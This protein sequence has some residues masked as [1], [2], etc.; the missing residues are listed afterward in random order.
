MTV[1][2]APG[3]AN[4]FPEYLRD[5]RG[6]NQACSVGLVCA[7]NLQPN[8]VFH[9]LGHAARA[10]STNAPVE[11][12]S[13][14][15]R[16]QIKSKS[17]DRV[18]T[19]QG[20]IRVLRVWRRALT[21]ISVEFITEQGCQTGVI[22]N[23]SH[24]GAGLTGCFDGCRG[25]VVTLHFN[26]G[27]LIPA[28]VR[29][30]RGYY[31]GVSFLEPLANDDPLLKGLVATA[32]APQQVQIAPATGASLQ[33]KLR[34]WVLGMAIRLLRQLKMSRQSAV[35]FLADGRK[36]KMVGDVHVVQSRDAKML[37]RACRKQG[38][39]WLVENSDFD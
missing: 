33:V 35:Q 29:W 8:W 6:R 14:H 16:E 26:D 17:P 30:H 27:R 3:L 11:Q 20:N 24:Q 1:K 19:E 23:I 15:G 9:M 5:L 31:C 13:Q 32:P 2:C 7:P 22:R 28:Q 4:C 37:A 25:D 21:R 39:A 34:D 38:Y 36:H 18:P 10:V 12:A